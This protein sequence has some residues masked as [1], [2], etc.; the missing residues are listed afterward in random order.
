MRCR[1]AA[2]ASGV[3]SALRVASR[4]YELQYPP[5]FRIDVKPGYRYNSKKI[6]HEL[7]VDVQNVTRNLNVFQQTYDIAHR[8]INTDYQL[9]FFVIPQYRILF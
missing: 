8:R 5:Y 1:K 6:T 3:S 4:A 2:S 9:R 7:S